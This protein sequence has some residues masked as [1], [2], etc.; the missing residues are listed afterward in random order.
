MLGNRKGY[1][2]CNNDTKFVADYVK[3]SVIPFASE[4]VPSA[5]HFRLQ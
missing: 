1:M 5:V 4:F 2:V 3:C